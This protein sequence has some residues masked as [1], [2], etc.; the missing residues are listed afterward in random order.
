[1]GILGDYMPN[2]LPD[3][4]DK[5]A[6]ARQGLLAFGGA[7]LGGRGNFGEVLG[8]GLMSGSQGYNGALVQQQQ[9]AL[10]QAQVDQTKLENQKLQAAAD[11]PMQLQ[12]ILAGGAP[13]QMGP[14]PGLPRIG[15]APTVDAA[16][17]ANPSAA[18][19]PAPASAAPADL[20]QTYM[21][22]GD[23]LTQAGRPA[24]AKPYYELAEKLR[25]KLKEQKVMT[26]G[27][28]QVLV[29]FDE[30]GNPTAVDGYAPAEKLNF[31][32]T[33]GSTVALDPFTGKPVNT[34][35]NTQSP[36]SVASVAEARRA[37]NMQHADNDPQAA[38]T[39]QAILNA[40]A[41]YNLDGTLPPMG[42][43]KN[44]AAGRSAIL[45]KAAELAAGIDPSQQ[46]RDQ[47]TTKN[48]LGSQG[49]A[50]KAFTSGKQGNS[51]RSFNVSLSHMDT[52]DQLADALHN[53]NAQ[54]VNKLGNYFA[55]QTGSPAPTNFDA[56]K[57]VVADEVVKAIVGSGGG[58]HDREEAARVIAAAN[59]PA[60]LKGVISTYKELM[61]GQL[62]G[63]EQQYK[64]STG[65]EDF[66]KFLSPAAKVTGLKDL[67]K[68]PAQAY[69]DPGKEE[70]YQAW[71]RSQAK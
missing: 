66:G 25:P 2:W 37:H 11:E 36:D 53:G 17:A 49:A 42:M 33:G 4:P 30:F 58:V 44:A 12:K 23:R 1:M 24:Q 14:P 57:K 31:Q 19:A 39:D 61:R 13:T 52:L 21:S 56:A 8:Q 70:R 69:A 60:Q 41:R 50:L 6:A 5:N 10:R 3:D 27:G 47:I 26:I 62:H 15:G 71:K 32:N 64:A 46:R 45:N 67:P 16:P 68:K 48:E 35:Q 20:F 55:T 40:A 59:S 22:Y 7:M 63:L 38:I 51:V 43:G 65:R 28:K 29:N 9:T 54:A 34:I 18:S